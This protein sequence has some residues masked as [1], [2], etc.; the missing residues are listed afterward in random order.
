MPGD[1]PSLLDLA[2]EVADGATVDW[3]RDEAKL[4]ESSGVVKQLRVLADVAELHRSHDED[5]ELLDSMSVTRTH[6]PDTTHGQEVTASLGDRWGDL[7]LLEEIG[8]G[9]FGTVYKAHDRNLDRT[10][11][12]KL[13]RPRSSTD[14][15]LVSRILHEG[16][17]LARVQHPNV[18]TVQAPGRT[19]TGSV[20]GWSSFA[21]RRC[22]RPHA[23]VERSALRRPPRSD[24]NS[25]KRSRSCTQRVWSTQTSRLRM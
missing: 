22:V 17:T 21:V 23:T 14:K 8:S 1:L 24:S 4:L 16:R 5:V 13:R 2:A 3:V 11:A 7:I 25:A 19:T 10:V 12:L 15:E 20:S 9:S 18:V 6:D